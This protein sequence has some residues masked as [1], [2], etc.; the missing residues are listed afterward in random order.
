MLNKYQLQAF[1]VADSKFLDSYQCVNYIRFESETLKSNKKY[2]CLQLFSV[3]GWS[4]IIQGKFFSLSLVDDAIFMNPEKIKSRVD[5][6]QD[7]IIG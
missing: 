4:C 6:R 5:Y 1:N 2:V 3:Q 7:T